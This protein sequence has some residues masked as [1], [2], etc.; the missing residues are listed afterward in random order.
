MASKATPKP[1]PVEVSQVEINATKLEKI[2]QEAIRTSKLGLPD[3]AAV[4]K[5]E[6]ISQEYLMQ[7]VEWARRMG[8]IK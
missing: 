3:W 1:E 8:L 4:A 6:H 2:I 5:N 7:R